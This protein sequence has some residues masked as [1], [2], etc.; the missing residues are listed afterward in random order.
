MNVQVESQ[1]DIVIRL[2]EGKKL[3][4]DS[5]SFKKTLEWISSYQG[6]VDYNRQRKL[7]SVACHAFDITEAEIYAG[8][9]GTPLALSNNGK[10]KYNSEK[11][12]ESI[13]PRGGWFEWYTEH[14]RK[15]ESP[16]SFHIFSSMC[17][18]G[19]ALGRRV[20]KRMGF[21]NIYPNYCAI[22]IG[23]TGRVK[24]TSAVN[25]AKGYIKNGALCPI[26]ADKITPERMQSVLARDGGIQFIYAP[27]ASVFFGRQKYNDGLTTLM[28]RL[29]DCPDSFDVETQARG[30]EVVENIALTI[31]A[32]STPSLLAGASPEEVTSSGFLNRFLLVVEDDTDREYPEPSIGPYGD[33]LAAT[34]ERFKGWSGEAVWTPRAYDWFKTWYHERKAKTRK[35]AD[36]TTAEIME[37]YPDHLIRTA[38]LVHLAQHDD[39]FICDECC[40]AAGRLLQYLE[41]CVPRTVQTLKQTL[42]AQDTEYVLEVLRRLGGAADHSKLL[43][44]VGSRLDASRFKKHI[45]TLI[46][47]KIVKEEIRG[48]VR[49]YIIVGGGG[50]EEQHVSA[51]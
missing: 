20:Y 28:L 11:A 35:A 9:S 5:P 39:L 36:D 8:I 38:L 32:G 25:I 49:Y 29:M 51:S 50:E 46:E 22:L 43:R 30:R 47:Q 31:L 1:L 48:A 16:L 41:N 21:F 12:L 27:E 26:M 23:P 13:L 17:V 34:V 15:T 19:A 37:R 33:K 45:G 3:S 14:T 2:L 18:L 6:D 4:R 42:I 40:V 24:K 7:I 44:R 10:P